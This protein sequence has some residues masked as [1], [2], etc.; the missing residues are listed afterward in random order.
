MVHGVAYCVDVMGW[1][2]AIA[3]QQ[4]PQYLHPLLLRFFDTRFSESTDL[5]DFIFYAYNSR[6]RLKIV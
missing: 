3:S 2:G 6:Q 1:G 5:F 4:P